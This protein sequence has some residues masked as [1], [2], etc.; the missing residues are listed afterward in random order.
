[1]PLPSESRPLYKST[2]RPRAGSYVSCPRIA[3]PGVRAAAQRTPPVRVRGVTRV[4]GGAAGGSLLPAPCLAARRRRRRRRDAAAHHL[5]GA[6][7]LRLVLARCAARARPRRMPAC[8]AEVHR[9]RVI[10]N[11]HGQVGARSLVLLQARRT[12][13]H[14]GSATE[15]AESQAAGRV[16]CAAWVEAMKTARAV[17]LG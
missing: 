17:F 6:P 1:M 2:A 15:V 5:Q 9:P 8:T 4:R 12:P 11:G 13:L 10:S 3:A 7:R 14:R 16:E